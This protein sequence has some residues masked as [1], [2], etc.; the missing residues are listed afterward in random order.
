M[1]EKFLVVQEGDKFSVTIS[2]GGS[3]TLKAFRLR[4]KPAVHDVKS[5]V[6]EFDERFNTPIRKKSFADLAEKMSA[7]MEVC[8]EGR[9]VKH[10]KTK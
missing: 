10:R 1:E 8:K 9:K 3:D 7:D 2:G 5:I 4:R 6:V